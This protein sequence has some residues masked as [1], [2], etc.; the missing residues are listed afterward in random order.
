M[1]T[2]PRSTMQIYTLPAFPSRCAKQR[3]T[4]SINPL[5]PNH[6][7]STHSTHDRL[8][9][10]GDPPNLQRPAP[11]QSSPLPHRTDGHTRCGHETQSIQ[12]STIIN[13]ITKNATIMQTINQHKNHN[14]ILYFSTSNE[15]GET[16]YSFTPDFEDI[17]TQEDQDLH[18][19]KSMQTTITKHQINTLKK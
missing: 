16:I 17:W 19:Q 1:A 4:L 6:E 8:H 10:G 18:N 2:A 9:R 15:T 13:Q 7:H 11:G 5:S 14:H 3:K 12:K